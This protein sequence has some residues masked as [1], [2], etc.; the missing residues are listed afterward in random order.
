ML[1]KG[2]CVF[3][4]GFLFVFFGFVFVFWFFLVTTATTICHK[5]NSVKATQRQN[6]AHGHQVYLKFTHT[7]IWDICVCSFVPFHLCWLPGTHIFGVPHIVWLLVHTGMHACVFT[8]QWAKVTKHSW[9]TERQNKVECWGKG[10][11]EKT[12][13]F[14]QLCLA[15]CVRENKQLCVCS[16]TICWLK[17]NNQYLKNTCWMHKL[18]VFHTCLVFH[19]ICE[20]NS[21]CN[22]VILHLVNSFIP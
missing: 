17:E 9:H 10:C 13:D 14:Y 22:Y 18:N 19:S 8:L 1:K 3:P 12:F 15:L 6:V 5:I 20:I 2:G 4:A 16:K 7:I 21:I 11:V